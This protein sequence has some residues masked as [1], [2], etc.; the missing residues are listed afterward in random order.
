MFTIDFIE[1]WNILNKRVNNEQPDLVEPLFKA[2]MGSFDEL[3]ANGNSISLNG[4]PIAKITIGTSGDEKLD[5]I[6]YICS[7]MISG[8]GTIFE[9]SFSIK[10][11][12]EFPNGIFIVICAII[13]NF[14]GSFN[15]VYPEEKMTLHFFYET[16][17]NGIGALGE[18]LNSLEQYYSWV[19]VNLNVSHK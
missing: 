11:A 10:F 15:V 6:A 8:N 12:D 3:R 13:E 2:H 14:E 7:Q 5:F 9:K 17:C 4:Q 19:K 1:N 16:A 18:N